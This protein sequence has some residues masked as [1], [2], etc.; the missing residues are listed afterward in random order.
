MPLFGSSSSAAAG[1]ASERNVGEGGARG[2]QD[3]Q[4]GRGV[5]VQDAIAARAKTV[6]SRK[7]V[8]AVKDLQVIVHMIHRAEVWR[9]VSNMHLFDFE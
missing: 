4:G 1:S 7:L 8:E 6:I 5:S 2:G 9:P 3:A